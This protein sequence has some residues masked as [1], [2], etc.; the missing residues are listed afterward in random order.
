MS[1]MR[2]GVV[3]LGFVGLPLAVAFAD[4]GCEVVGVD[5]DPDRL[6]ML[7][8]GQSYLAHV[9][10][11]TFAE[12]GDRLRSGD[13]YEPLAD[14]DAIVVAV[15]T[16][17]DAERR[18]DPG[19]LAS[20]AQQLSSVL[21]PGQLISVESTTYPGCTRELVAPLLERGGLTAGEDFNLAFSP[22]R[23]S[24]ARPEFPLRSIPKVVSGLTGEC[25]S[26][27]A[28]L[29]DL[30]CDEIVPVASLEAAEATKLLEN[31]FRFVNVSLV[32]EFSLICD[33][34]GIEVHD[35]IDAASTKPFGFM[36]FDPGP[37]AGG[38]CL[39]VDAAYLAWRAREAGQPAHLIEAAI[40]VDRT[41]PR[42]CAERIRER[43]R[44]RGR[45]LSGASVLVVGVTYKPGIADLRESPALE[46][47]ELLLA[48]GADAAYYDPLVP[49]L[50]KHS[51]SSVPLE[52]GLGD[53]D[54]VV[55]ASPG[56]GVDLDR[57]AGESSD[58]LDL[59][60]VT[61]AARSG[62]PART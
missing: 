57:I 37:G 34:L 16:P 59:R 47:L 52:R 4:A 35:V 25:R 23:L 19:P 5:T 55:L 28:E 22:E 54:L 51:L 9:S 46:L 42:A 17:L 18:P 58:L 43:L 33:R 2:V 31:V 11:D 29:F 13:R 56:P 21:R 49:T 24:V 12:I 60:G 50:E 36:R 39:P 8:G 61:R 3:G 40:E 45:E 20:A 26:R 1:P 62:V 53:F 10:D 32:N 30:V 41:M 6:R 44:A 15:P 38:H 14:V 48:A 7:K 27:A